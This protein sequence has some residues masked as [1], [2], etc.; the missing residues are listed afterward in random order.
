[1]KWAILG[2]GN[3]ANS[4]ARSFQNEQA[5][6]YAVA[7]RSL[8][9]AEEFAGKYAI[10]VSYGSYEEMLADEAID[11]VYIAT[12][13]SHHYQQIKLCL[14]A[15][16]HVFC[17]KVM[18]T[19]MK[20]LDEVVEL[21]RTKK[22]YLA[23]AMTIFHVPLYPKLKRW[24]KENN[25]GKVKMIHA[26]YGAYKPADSPMYFYQKEL[27]G[28][29][30]FDIGT[31]ALT[32]ALEFMSS[33]PS[34]IVTLGNLHESGVDESSVIVLRNQEQE[35]AT[36]ELSFATNLPHVGVVAF[37][38]GHLEIPNYPRAKRAVFKNLEGEETII[39]VDDEEHA[40]THEI[41]H[42]TKM[43]LAKAENPTLTKTKRV[44]EVMDVV[45]REWGLVYP[46]D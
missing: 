44:M 12:P 15:G 24:I 2:A 26:P 17:E 14:E 20:Q 9:K 45:R 42:F 40:F 21:A 16:K 8:E 38:K 37:E 3:I 46:F 33:P 18:V 43:V 23:E 1:M 25:V 19:S 39:E 41:N 7:S 36:V 32:F 5:E 22:L 4:F 35:L 11:A 28:G 34:D 30:L 6:L 31:Y 13:H 27:A 10:P 29:A